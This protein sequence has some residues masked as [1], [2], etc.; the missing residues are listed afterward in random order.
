MI[1]CG[2]SGTRLWPVSRAAYPKQLMPLTSELTLLQETLQR[3]AD[4]A[5]FAAPLVVCNDEHRFLVAEQA[6]ALGGAPITILLEP[7]GR[8]TAPAIAAAAHL[9]A[10]QDG[11][12]VMLV[13]PSDHY[14]AAPGRFREAVDQAVRAAD[15][16]ALVT[17]GIA[18]DK[19]ET[20]YGYVR[21]GAALA[22]CP[23][24]FAVDRFVEKP[25]RATAEAYLAEGGYAWNSG[26]FLFRAARYLA[27]LA[28]LEP[29]MLA[30]TRE[31]VARAVR[32]LD[33]LRLD[34]EAFAGAPAR[35]ID[36]AVMERTDS[37]A[38]VP[39]DIGWS[40]VGSWAALWETAAKD[41]AGNTLIGDVLAAG[42]RN[43]YIRAESRLVAAVG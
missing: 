23:G 14:V 8:N 2:G 4:P 32:D 31:A 36:Y 42:L 16:G 21:Q 35:S 19:P 13:L 34:Q 27:E 1:L 10:A 9:L 18:P 25:D 3:V 33:F 11:E 17:F 37:A 43:S 40:D 29:A 20:G 6:R 26:M 30:A 5:R 12:A 7:T 15:A 41:G 39:L 38:V 22:G 28:R 24:C